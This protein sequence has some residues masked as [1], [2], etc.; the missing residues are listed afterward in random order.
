MTR[1]NPQERLSASQ[2]NSQFDLIVKGLSSVSLRWRLKERDSYLFIIALKDVGVV[3]SE[4][5][6]ALSSRI[7]AYISCNSNCSFNS[8]MIT[9]LS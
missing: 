6:S 8:L 2:A 9:K 5:Y 3:V 7:G 4:I 1:E